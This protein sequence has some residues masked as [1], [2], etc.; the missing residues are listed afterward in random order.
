MIAILSE[1]FFWEPLNVGLQGLYLPNLALVL[2]LW[3]LEFH[4]DDLISANRCSKAEQRRETETDTI[5]WRFVRKFRLTPRKEASHCNAYAEVI[6]GRRVQPRPC[7]HKKVPVSVLGDKFKLFVDFEFLTQK[8]TVFA[9]NFVRVKISYSSVRGLPYAIDFRTSR[10]VSQTLV[11]AF[12]FGM[13]QNSVLSAKSMTNTKL[14]CARKCLWSQST[15]G[16]SDQFTARNCTEDKVLAFENFQD[17]S[18]NDELWCTNLS[19]LT[20]ELQTQS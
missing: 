13:L 12:G 3:A 7:S 14:N 19:S 5:W 1:I 8:G 11:N 2:V 9:E 17:S 15:W 20:P 10:A 18:S 6:G 16:I 4:R